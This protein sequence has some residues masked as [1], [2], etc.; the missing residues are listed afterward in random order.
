MDF[1]WETE[2][3]NLYKDAPDLTVDEP[4][5]K[6]GLTSTPAC[7]LYLDGCRVPC[8]NFSGASEMQCNSIANESGL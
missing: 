5:H 8:T 6:I 2:Q 7:Q 4:F 1:S 3:T